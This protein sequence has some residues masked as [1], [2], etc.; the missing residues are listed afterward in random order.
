VTCGRYV[1]EPTSL[2]PTGHHLIRGRIRSVPGG[3]YRSS[4]PGLSLIVAHLELS[5]LRIR[6]DRPASGPVVVSLSGQRWTSLIDSILIRSCSGVME[7]DPDRGHVDGSAPDEVAFVVPGRDGAVLA[8]LA[9]GPLD[10]VALLVRGSVEG[11]RPSTFAAAPDLVAGL[12]R[13][14]GNRDLDPAPGAGGRGSR[15]WSRPYRPNS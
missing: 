5:L 2:R 12:V 15:C 8:E 14:L 3:P 9:E 7:P 6:W 13:G 10:D 4:R 11:G 1:A